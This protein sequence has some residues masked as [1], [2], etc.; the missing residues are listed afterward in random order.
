VWGYTPEYPNLYG[1]LNPWPYFDHGLA[2]S[3]PKVVHSLANQIVRTGPSASEYTAELGNVK[4]DQSFVATQQV[5]DWFEIDFP[6]ENGPAKGWIQAEDAT[7]VNHWKIN[8]PS[9][10]V[11]GVSVCTTTATCASSAARL[12]YLW[13]QQ[14]I[15]ELEQAPAQTGCSKPWIKTNLLE[16]TTGWVCSEFLT[17]ETVIPPTPTGKL[18]DTGI[19]ACSNATTNNLTCPIA[20]F[21]EQDA[22]FGRDVTHNDNSDGHAGFSFTKLDSNGNPLPANASAWDCV[23]DNI[24][25]LIWEVKTDDG[26]LRDKDNTYTWYEPDDSK[27]GG[28]AGTQNGGSCTGSACDTYGYVQAVNAQGLCGASNWRMPDVNELLLIVNNARF[29]PAIDIN[30]FP[31]TPASNVWSSSPVASNLNPALLAAWLVDFN[32]GYDDINHKTS[33]Y[34]VR[35]VRSGQ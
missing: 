5:G 11:I 29:N 23:K 33:S 7:N 16:G 18:N 10:G 8:D 13:D 6:S 26:G 21:P 12:N 28:S 4:L 24:T 3:S 19:T 9:R 35:L 20:D 17:N 27:N 22:Q 30:Y 1:Y 2:A 31:N 25:D 32:H 34:R 15:V 14:H